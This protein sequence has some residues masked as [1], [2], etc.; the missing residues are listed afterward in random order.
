M[1]ILPPSQHRRPSYEPSSHIIILLSESVT[2]PFVESTLVVW[3][4][5]LATAG[6]SAPSHGG[7]DLWR[8]VAFVC[9]VESSDPEI[10]RGEMVLRGHDMNRSPILIYCAYKVACLAHQ[11]P[12]IPRLHLRIPLGPTVLIWDVPNGQLRHDRNVCRHTHIEQLARPTTTR[13]K[14]IQSDLMLS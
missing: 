13:R 9:V 3:L 6:L 11:C 1:N 10:H 4:R 12:A 14:C 2:F 5:T 7:H 8:A